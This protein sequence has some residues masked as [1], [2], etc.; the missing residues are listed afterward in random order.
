M[1]GGSDTP[2]EERVK[3]LLEHQE[4]RPDRT[5]SIMFFVGLLVGYCLSTV[6][7]SVPARNQKMRSD[8]TRQWT[9]R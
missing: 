6:L 9:M 7:A 5:R 8:Y 4:K 2:F 1:Y 3:S